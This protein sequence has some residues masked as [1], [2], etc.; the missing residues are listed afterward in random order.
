MKYGL[1]LNEEGRVLSVCR[2]AFASADS[3]LVE[4]I[5]ENDILDYIYVDG[6]LK[7]Y[8][9]IKTQ[10]EEVP[11]SMDWIEAQLAYTAMMT[12]TLLE[13]LQNV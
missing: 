1:N 3:V 2:A 4:E 13:G 11:D 12:D 6:E 5:P 8:P 10:V 7:Y 9:E